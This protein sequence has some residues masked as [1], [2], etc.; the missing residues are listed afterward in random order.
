[1]RPGNR[2][3]VNLLAAWHLAKPFE[4]AVPAEAPLPA[5]GGDR[6]AVPVYDFPNQR[7]VDHFIPDMP[8]RVSA[9]RTLGGF[10]EHLCAGI[11]HRRGGRCRR[12]RPHSVSSEPSEGTNVA[13]PCC[14]PPLTRQAGK[15]A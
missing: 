7:I 5:G 10:R 1:M 13:A 14:R 3:G 6:N 12:V 9:L 4:R 8:I 2:Q 11:L 15:L